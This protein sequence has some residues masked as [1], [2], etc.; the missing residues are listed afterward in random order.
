MTEITA[1]CRAWLEAQRLGEPM[2]LATLVRVEGSS[3]RRPGA[4][5]L[6]GRDGVRAGSVSGGCL[7]HELVRS[8]GW[9]TEN[10]PVCR[11][12][13]AGADEE[14][15]TDEGATRGSGCLG[16]LELLLEPLSAV[17]DAAL[18]AIARELAAERPVALATVLASRLPHVRVGARLL[19]SERT[20]VTELPALNPGPNLAELAARA[21]AA[22]E[23]RAALVE[24]AGT[25]ALVEVLEPPPHLFVFGAG[26]DAVPVVRLATL[27]GWNVTVAGGE[28]R[29]LRAVRRGPG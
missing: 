23:A 25:T 19:K 13:D 6:F 12:V 17:A 22:R 18:G 14:D 10:G 20:L 8:A 4:R 2:W 11:T 16:R 27:L 7:E 21:L 1:V 26:V 9:L 24:S 5:L 28:G 3:Y 29:R 15:A